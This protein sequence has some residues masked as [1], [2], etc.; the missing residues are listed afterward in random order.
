ME[1]KEIDF[2][3]IDLEGLS[4]VDLDN[5]LSEVDLDGIE[6]KKE[7]ESL[8]VEQDNTL[9]F[10]GSIEEIVV[11]DN[12]NPDSNFTFEYIDINNIAIP[13][14]RIREQ[15]RIEALLKSIKTTGL[16]EPLVIAPTATEGLYVLLSGFRRLVA[17]ARTG[18]KEIPCIINHK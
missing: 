9:N 8:I 1:N 2:S 5:I 12:V 11:M 3:D 16:L 4:D 6:D 17:C 14:S 18:I 7:Q 15:P 10:I 13:P